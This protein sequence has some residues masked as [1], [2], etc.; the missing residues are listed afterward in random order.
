MRFL[1]FQILLFQKKDIQILNFE[2][3][4]TERKQWDRGIFQTSKKKLKPFS[5]KKL[6][7]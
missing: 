5:L 6:E 7:I 2:K 1:Q 3:E 4:Q